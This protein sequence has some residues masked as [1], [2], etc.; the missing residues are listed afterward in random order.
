MTQLLMFAHWDYSLFIACFRDDVQQNLM[1]RHTELP[2]LASKKSTAER[3]DGDISR[4]RSFLSNTCDTYM[5]HAT[6][7]PQT[8][9]KYQ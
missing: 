3:S 4:S 5:N 2:T 9:H 7:I 8:S 6:N 1:F